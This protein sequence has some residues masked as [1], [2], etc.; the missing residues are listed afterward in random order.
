V[1]PR[2][3]FFRRG[4]EPPLPVILEEAEIS[5]ARRAGGGL[6]RGGH[7]PRKLMAPFRG[8]ERAHVP[9]RPDAPSLDLQPLRRPGL[10]AL[11]RD[12]A[13]PGE[14]VRLNVVVADPPE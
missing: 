1:R 13:D 4:V 7:D 6:P 14:V 10:P 11:R 5:L 9:G 3:V 8:S 2:R 12:V